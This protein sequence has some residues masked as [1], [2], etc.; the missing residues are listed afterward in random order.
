MVT[1]IFRTSLN[2]CDV[3]QVMR[4]LA[5][6]LGLLV[7][8][9]RGAAT[10]LE[11]DLLSLVQEVTALQ[12]LTKDY[13]STSSLSPISCR[14]DSAAL[15]DSDLQQQQPQ[16]RNRALPPQ[17]PLRQA[18]E[19]ER[20]GLLRG[21][22]AVREVQLLLKSVVGSDP[23][24]PSP[25]SASSEAR[26]RRASG[27]E[28]WGEAPTDPV[29]AA[30]VKAAV[31]GLEK[32]LAE[33]FG[34]VERY[35][36]P[37]SAMACTGED[38]GQG[39]DGGSLAPPLLAAGAAQ[40]VVETR[41]ALRACT[42][43]A[44]GISERFAGVL[45]RA[46]LVRV[47]QHLSDVDDEVGLVL[48][49][50]ELMRSWL[51][52]D[53]SAAAADGGSNAVSM[54]V[55]GDSVDGSPAPDA[56]QQAAAEHAT[57]V[58]QRLTDAVKAMLLSV[59][60]LCPRDT[61][62]A[63]VTASSAPTPVKTEPGDAANAGD[64]SGHENEEEEGGWSTGT[65]LFEAHACAFEQASKLKLWRCASA[66]AAARVALKELSEDEAVG[67]AGCGVAGE[68]AAALVALCSEVLVLAEQVLSAGKA[69]LL[70]M[71]ALNKVGP[72]FIRNTCDSN[73]GS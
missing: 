19:T 63:P 34:R 36:S 2:K 71:L 31:D 21:L 58:G 49:G 72:I 33:T 30:E 37:L 22:E 16:Q 38:E 11:G 10:A 7:L 50:S 70:G 41:E 55:G 51:L 6:H 62:V 29:T 15:T 25:A 68:A 39:E 61:A 66:M 9:Q 3:R 65:T 46:V 44:R 47:A 26:L 67:V 56:Q 1:N 52:A 54:E 45:P 14:E 48:D 12:S 27:G 53:A 57:R 60:A 59:Q 28:G 32:S 43:D 69:V 24:A 64:E 13:G 8:Q 40:V 17:G 20:Q 23:P 73:E 18:L 5:E 42:A 35:P 4:G